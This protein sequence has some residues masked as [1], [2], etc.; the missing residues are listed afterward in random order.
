M[1]VLAC[2]CCQTF[3][4]WWIEPCNNATYELHFSTLPVKQYK[5]GQWS[6]LANYLLMLSMY[7]DSQPILVISISSDILANI[8]DWPIITQCISN[9]DDAD[10]AFSCSVAWNAAHV[11]WAWLLC[12]VIRTV[13]AFS[14]MWNANAWALQCRSVIIAKLLSASSA[15][16]GLHQPW[17]SS[18]LTHSS[19]VL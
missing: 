18:G 10:I 12:R 16:W 6:A 5:I 15:W 19:V 1:E 9:D 8:Y 17:T 7:V 14:M 3:L 13:A 2:C 11:A 4:Q